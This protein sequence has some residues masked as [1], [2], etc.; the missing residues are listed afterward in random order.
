MREG[1]TQVS[2]GIDET[3][4][5]EV[6]RPEWRVRVWTLERRMASLEGALFEFPNEEAWERKERRKRVVVR[7]QCMF[8]CF[9]Q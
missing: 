8:S 5:L 4:R 9:L 1:P 6:C 3:R 2:C 7:K